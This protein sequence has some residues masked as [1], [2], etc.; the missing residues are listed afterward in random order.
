MERWGGWSRS[1]A[2]WLWAPGSSPP[3]AMATQSLSPCPAANGT[4]SP[5]CAFQNS[6]I[7]LERADLLSLAH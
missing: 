2:V 1:T 4:L 7:G 5:V 3:L 6:V